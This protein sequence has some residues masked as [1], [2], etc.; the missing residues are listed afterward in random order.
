MRTFL[1][2]LIAVFLFVLWFVPLYAIEF[3][4]G[5]GD[6]GVLYIPIALLSF[7]YGVLLTDKFDEL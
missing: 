3:L 4:G 6:W 7:F 5:T 2:I 1:L